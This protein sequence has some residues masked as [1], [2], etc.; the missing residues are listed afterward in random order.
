MIK[1]KGITAA[2]LT[3]LLA[4]VLFVGGG[5]YSASAKQFL[6]DGENAAYAP[7]YATLDAAK[8]GGNALNERIGEEGMILM[9][10]DNDTLPLTAEERTVSVFGS[11][12]ADMVNGGGGSGSGKPYDPITFTEAMEQSGFELNP[13]LKELYATRNTRNEIAVNS[14]NYTPSIESTY[15]DYNDAALIVF[16]RYAQEGTD[17]DAGKGGSH[18]LEPKE[19]ELALLEY[20]KGLKKEDGSFMFDKIILL[21]NVGNVVEIQP[22]IDDPRVQSVLYVGYGGSRGIA[23]APRILNGEVNPSGHTV[24]VWPSDFR[25][26]PTW[27]NF[28]ENA[29]VGSTTINTGTGPDGQELAKSVRSLDYEEGIYVGYKWYET[30]STIDDYYTLTE[31]NKSAIAGQENDPYYNRTNGVI[32]P[33]G[34]GMSYTSFEWTVGEPSFSGEITKEHAGDRI[35]V[36]VTVKNTGEVAG[37]DVVQVYVRAPYDPVTAP[38]EKS[39]VSMVAFEKTELLAPGQ[40]Q[41]LTLSFDVSDM[42]SFDWNDINKNSFKGYEL[43]GGTYEVLFRTDSHT[44]KIPGFSVNYTVAEEGIC[45]NE[46]GID[47]PLNYNKGYGEETAK[48]VFSNED[49]YNT[50]RTGKIYENGEHV[51]ASAEGDATYISRS[52]W[53]LPAPPVAAELAYSQAAIDEVF[54]HIYYGACYDKPTDPWYKTEEDIPGYGTTE[55]VEGGWKQAPM[56]SDPNRV[57]DIQ[58]KDMTGVPLDDPLWVEFMNQLTWAEMTNLLTQ[59]YF[60]TPE[61]PAV[62]KPYTFDADG[63]AQLRNVKNGGATGTFWCSATLISSTYNKA[64]CYEQGS[65]VATEGMLMSYK[66]D[67]HELAYVNGWYGPGLNTHRSPFGGRNFEY[68]SQDGVQGG[69]IGGAVIAGATEQGMHV[70]GKHYVVNDQDTDRKSNGGISVWC[71]EQA[72][73]EI[74]MKQFEYAVE[75]GNMNGMMNSH[76]RLGLYATQ[77]NFYLN[78]VVPRN[79]WGFEGVSVTDLVDSVPVTNGRTTVS[80]ADMLIRSGSTFMGNLANQSKGEQLWFDGRILDGYYDAATNKLMVPESLTVTNWKSANRDASNIQNIYYSADVS[81]GNFSLS[82]PTQWYWVRMTAMNSLY[83]AANSNQMQAVADSNVVG[84][85][86]SVNYNDGVTPSEG[87]IVNKGDTIEAPADP[88]VPEGKRFAGWYTNAECTEPM[89]FTAPVT[90]YTALYALI[91][92]SN[93]FS[94]RFD[95]NYKGAPAAGMI[96]NEKGK[97]ITAPP[98]TPSRDG[99][100]FGGWYLEPECDT[101]AD[102]SAIDTE[103]DITFYAKWI[104]IADYVITYDMNYDGVFHKTTV[105]VKAGEKIPLLAFSPERS[106]YRF[107]GWYRDSYCNSPVNY[108]AEVTSDMTLYAKWTKIDAAVEDTAGSADFRVAFF[109]TLGVG[110]AA[111]A[112]FVILLVMKFVGNKGE[113]R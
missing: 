82:S 66:A 30:A 68:Y 26:D 31:E 93:Q 18:E 101:A 88:V 10:N 109:V 8:R 103:E 55:Y 4:A 29:Q 44:D 60:N 100:E 57:C 110:I 73:R 32:F 45:Y 112:G 46:D 37:K 102:F 83:V 20:V 7:A 48:A 76:G 25:Q 58:L 13:A 90:G 75:Y 28:G 111:L 106:G 1:R 70:Y 39:D 22:Y 14:T 61:I 98:Y 65:H 80:N 34:Y 5:V 42:A 54:S 96:M 97:P 79:E 38:I 12:S 6:P 52:N 63:P 59:C 27:Y 94:V 81:C 35:T 71:N 17:M 23:A 49:T 62:G 56:G 2:L 3:L 33:F 77:N 9:K 53:K 107:D 74:Y 15:A 67:G 24:D 113:K 47:N 36:P 87:Y 69:L 51:N 41:T 19:N 108:D 95:F 21:L 92:D 84:A 85:Y 72:L 11:A 89:D 104:R 99:Y 50:S 86:I 105:V 43:E 40:E 16:T 78:T 91:V 64:L